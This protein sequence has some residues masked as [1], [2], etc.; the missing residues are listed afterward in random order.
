MNGSAMAAI[1]VAIA[2]ITEVIMKGTTTFKFS[3]E[4]YY[5]R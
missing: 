5:E 3:K 4:E 2:I 1:L